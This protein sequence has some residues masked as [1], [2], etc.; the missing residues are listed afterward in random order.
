MLPMI[1]GRRPSHPL[2]TFGARYLA[3]ALLLCSCSFSQEQGIPVT[4]DGHEVVRV[5]GSLGSFSAGDRADA[6]HDRILRLAKVKFTEQLDTRE[7]PSQ[8]A[9]AVYAGSTIIMAVTQLD[10]ELAG[11]PRQ[12]LAKQYAVAIRKAIEE[13]RARHTWNGAL[14]ALLETMFIW[15]V[16]C[17][18][19][20]AL[21]RAIR[22]I[23][24]LSARWVSTWMA[25]RVP[26]GAHRVLLDRGRALLLTTIKGA[27]GILLLFV[28]SFAISYTFSL[29]PAT[30]GISTTVLDYLLETFSR[31]GWAILN[32]LPSGGFVIIVCLVTYYLLRVLRLLSRLVE[33]GDLPVGI[34]H[35]EMARPTYQLARFVVI[36]FALVVAFPY[37]P[38]GKSDAF[39][40]VTIFLGLLLSLGS[41]SAVTNVLAGLVLTYMRAFRIGDRVKIADTVGDVLEKSLLVTRIRTIKNVEVVIP[42]GAILTGQV[43]NYSAMARSRG[44]ILHTTVTIGY[45][46]PWRKVHDLLIGAAL[47]TSGVL[48]DPKP[49]VLETSLNDFHISYELNAYTDRPQEIQNIYSELHQAIQDSFNEGGVEIMSPSFYAL[50]DGNTVTTPANHRP[51]G[52]EA[53]SFRV[54]DTKPSGKGAANRAAGGV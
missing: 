35:P 5:Y 19:G 34:I 14:L 25:E 13:Y 22:W 1:N 44:L 47:N 46:A 40:A 11:T 53:P 16:Y 17:T 10:A 12:E 36:L 2:R 37:L 33:A 3:L 41:S 39:K 24:S 54:R 26:R 45:D 9:T 8:N 38:G 32:Y 31:A 50:R 48:S 7:V 30:A 18:G 49:F 51:T 6:I 43:L 20:W 21:W 4:I 28:F 52:Y 23:D 27:A 15:A 42:N 29:Y